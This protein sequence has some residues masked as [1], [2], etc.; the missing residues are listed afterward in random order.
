MD[1]GLFVFLIQL[2]R[3]NLLENI[4]DWMAM[5]YEFGDTA[6]EYYEKMKDEINFPDW[7]IKLMYEIFDCVY[8]EK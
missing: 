3:S 7:A 2:E 5:G 6:K 8:Q 1:I 4:V